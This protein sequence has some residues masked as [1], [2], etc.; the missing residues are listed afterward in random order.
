MFN[1]ISP[2]ILALVVLTGHQ[3]IASQSA[4]SSKGFDLVDKAGNIRKPADVR[5]RYQ[6]L[7]V[8]T[9]VDLNNNTEMHYTYA[10]PGTA[11]NYRKTGIFSDAIVA[12]VRNVEVACFI[13][14]NTVSLVNFG[15]DG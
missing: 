7:G 8:Y 2:L 1:R 5:D 9:P 10:T 3:P 15:A 6:A 13:E 11:E 12:S 14:P 4:G